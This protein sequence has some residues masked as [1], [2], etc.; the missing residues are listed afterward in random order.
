[1]PIADDHRRTA[2]RFERYSAE[3]GSLD[4]GWAITALFYAALHWIELYFYVDQ[5]EG[6]PRHYTDHARR[7][8]A[9]RRRLRPVYA[10]YLALR[11][12][13]EDHRYR[14]VVHKPPDVG[15]ASRSWYE[16][17]KAEVRRR[18]GEIP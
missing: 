15:I 16:P 6:E 1:V 5:V 14:C 2:D 12:A 4:P 9:V 7:L 3:H 17:L 18:L 10:E 8:D 11:T 13:S